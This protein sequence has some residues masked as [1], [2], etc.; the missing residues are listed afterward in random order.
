M[1]DA[2]ACTASSR[3]ADVSTSALER[4]VVE[5]QRAPGTR[6]DERGLA[7]EFCVSRTRS[8]TARNTR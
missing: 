6:L 7:E 5:V 1:G 8:R 2:T 4:Q 3:K